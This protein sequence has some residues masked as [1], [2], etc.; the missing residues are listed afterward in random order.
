MAH[1]LQEIE[2]SLFSA[3]QK[4]LSK[5]LNSEQFALIKPYL[6]LAQNALLKQ[7]SE[8]LMA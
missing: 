8:E 6:D 3:L 2:Q 7:K 4:R 5:N 1:Q